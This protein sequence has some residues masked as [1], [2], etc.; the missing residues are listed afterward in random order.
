MPHT[1]TD[2]ADVRDMLVVH[3]AFRQSYARLPGLVR[4]V[5]PGDVQRAAVVADHAR[6]IEEFL[7]LHHKGEDEL[8]WPKLLD[9]AGDRLG[10]AVAVLE[11][12]HEEIAAL[13]A[14]SAQR[15]A[16][17]RAQPEKESGERL[18]GS[19]ERLGSLL[20]EHLGIEEKDVLPIVPEYVTAK[21]W[22][23]LGDHAI[24]ALPKSKLPIVFGMLASYADPDV[25]KL[26]LSTAPL[27]PRLIMPVVGPKAYAR[28]ARK[29]YGAAA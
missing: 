26:M 27:V 9:R 7:H 1:S 11:S 4:E 6:L 12:Q 29:V 17:W 2:R 3:E 5:G 14:E 18:A 23:Q 19:L 24:N 25:V 28:H 15:L 10:D 21:E 22:H 8:L 13:L 20:T 16:V